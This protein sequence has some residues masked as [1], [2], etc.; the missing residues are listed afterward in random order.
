MVDDNFH[1]MDEDERREYGSYPTLKEAIAT[2][3]RLVDASLAASHRP[4][5]TAKELFDHY[6]AF[7]D[8]P[9]IVAP[10][11][12]EKGVI[13]SAH[14]YARKRAEAI[15]GIGGAKNGS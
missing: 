8:D 14:D 15:C 11:D 10:P 3:E 13:F 9:F 4:G 6:A 5:M 12:T 7:G 2:C 1:Y